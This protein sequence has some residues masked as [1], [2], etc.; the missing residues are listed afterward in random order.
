MDLSCS[1]MWLNCVERNI[2][3]YIGFHGYAD[4]CCRVGWSVVDSDLSLGED[5][6]SY[7]FGA[8]GRASTN[9]QFQLYGEAYGPGDFIG[10]FVVSVLC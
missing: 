2:K 7:G 4:C 8:T 10:C 5:K 6:L 1:L 9:K 3:L